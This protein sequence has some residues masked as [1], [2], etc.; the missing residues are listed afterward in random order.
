MF[1]ILLFLIILPVALATGNRCSPA[2][3]PAGR[4]VDERLDRIRKND[5]PPRPGDL[6]FRKGSGLVSALILSGNPEGIA[7]THTGVII[8]SK[9][10]SPANEKRKL[11][12]AALQVVDI[13]GDQFNNRIRVT[14]LASFVK[15]SVEGSICILRF[16]KDPSEGSSIARAALLQWEQKIPFDYDFNL[17]DHDSLYC[18]EMVQQT[19]LTATGIDINTNPILHQ[20]KSYIGFGSFINEEFFLPIYG[21]K[22]C[23][24]NR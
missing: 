9:V 12:P 21:E 5:V 7:L 10:S 18:T 3:P 20:G 23:P 15:N 16:R 19:I 13:V 14:S 17:D 4:S 11:D 22:D 2:A 8:H 6:I 1:R 24:L